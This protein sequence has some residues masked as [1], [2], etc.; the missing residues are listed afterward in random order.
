MFV[1]HR[2]FTTAAEIHANH[3]ALQSKF[4]SPRKPPS[5]AP[6]PPPVVI[7]TK[8][9]PKPTPL[10]KAA[11]TQFNS[12]VI[13]YRMYMLAC[14]EGRLYRPAK[15]KRSMDDIAADVLRFFPGKR[16]AMIKGVQRTKDIVLPRH[17]ILYEIRT[18]R[19]DKSFPEIA[20][21]CGGID[22]TSAIFAYRKIERMR[23]DGMLAWYFDRDRGD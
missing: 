8:P 20:R 22:H 11:P 10:W 14:E 21:W 6:E 5:P 19:P 12:H 3:V 2:E 23:E 15:P 17:I 13:D 9:A 16:L 1:S 18:Q 7:V 4:Y